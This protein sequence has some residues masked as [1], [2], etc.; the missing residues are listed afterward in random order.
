M[1]LCVCVCLYIYLCHKKLVS[2][3][4]PE[5]T[6]PMPRQIY[7]PCYCWRW[8]SPQLI[9]L[10]KWRRLSMHEIKQAVNYMGPELL[11]RN[12]PPPPASVSVHFFTDIWTFWNISFNQ[13]NI[14]SKYLV[15]NFLWK[16]EIHQNMKNTLENLKNL[17]LY[18][19]FAAIFY[20]QCFKS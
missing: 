6:K 14:E 16:L 10:L 17:I 8:A 7:L 20:H 4:R 13:N 3:L 12:A 9:L 1:R 15:D 2:R 19:V 18:F 11:W 5:I